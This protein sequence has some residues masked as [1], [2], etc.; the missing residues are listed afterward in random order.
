MPG[1]AGPI[2][3]GAP[4]PGEVAMNRQSLAVL[5]LAAIFTAAPARAQTY[6]GAF[7]YQGLLTDTGGPATGSYDMEFALLSAPI[8][9]TLIASVSIPNVPVSAGLFTARLN[10]DGSQFSS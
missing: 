9:G 8:S 1:C 6:S 2:L 7:T 10:F 4:G 3:P 5:A